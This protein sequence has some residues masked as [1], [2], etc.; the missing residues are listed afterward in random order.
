MIGETASRRTPV[1]R[2]RLRH[3]L[4]FALLVLVVVAAALVSPLGLLM[5]APALVLVGLLLS[6]HAPGEELLLRWANRH[7]RPP[8]PARRIERQYAA[9]F[10]RRVGRLIADALAMRPPPCAGSPTPA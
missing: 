5:L 4:P 2:A 9:V 8:R 1:R 6:G 10:V 7:K 3:P